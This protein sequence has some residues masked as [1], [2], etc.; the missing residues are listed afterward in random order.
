MSQYQ[1]RVAL[2]NGYEEAGS[3]VLDVSDAGTVHLLHCS[4]LPFDE[5]SLPYERSARLFRLVEVQLTGEDRESHHD[6]KHIGSQPAG[7]L[8][9]VRHRDETRTQGRLL[10]IDQLDAVTGLLVTSH[11][12][13]FSALPVV[14]SWTTVV[15]QGPAAQTLE[16]VS[17]F[18]LDGLA[19]EG[20]LPWDEKMQLG[21]PHNAWYGEVQWCFSSFPA[22]GFFRLDTGTS[23]STKR[24][25]YG[26]LGTW[27]TAQWLPMG[28]LENL[29]AGAGIAWQIEHNG[30]WHWEVSDDTG[31]I[32]LRL[33]G[34]TDQESQWSKTLAPGEQFTSVP[35]ALSVG[36]SQSNALTPF[37]STMRALTG[38]RR[39]IRRPHSD[40][41]LLPVIF[42]D[43]MNCLNA[44]P[45]TEKELPLI[46]AAARAGC[47]I[48]CVDAGWYADG[49]WW[50]SV[51]EWLPSSK[52]FPNGIEE[53]FSAIQA[54][55][56]IPGL[57]L[58]LEVM[59]VHC[60]LASRVPDNWFFCRKGKR[61]IDH[62]RYQLDYRH[63][64]VRAYADEILDRL[65][66][67]YG[68]GY[69]K[70]DYNINAGVGTELSAE[71]AGDGLL[72]HNRAYLDW[73]EK[74]IDRYPE[75]IIENC[76]SG[77]MRMDYALLSRHSVQ[78]VSD[79]T[80]YRKMSVIAV[81][82]PTAVTPEQGAIWAYPLATDDMHAVSYNMVNALLGRVH[83]SGQLAQLDTAHFRL[84]QEAI[85]V[86]KTFRAGLPEAVPYWPLGL[87]NF[88]SEWLCLGLRMDDS[89]YLA[90]WRQ[91]S[92][93]SERVIPLQALQ[94]RAL[95]VESLYPAQEEGAWH[96]NVQHQQ[97]HV[98]LPQRYS[99]R[100]FRVQTFSSQE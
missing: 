57:W 88:S 85:T 75:L 47:E 73:L 87:P 21:V 34:P 65:I 98:S 16:Y 91:D 100:L 26:S 94:D 60:P 13:F 82:A 52:R 24:L 29:E 96:L 28:Y 22:L 36:R 64:G 53:V 54:H 89:L 42:N 41:A 61:V 49:D 40:T 19:K 45:T 27:S 35:V 2:M 18:A 5:T 74:V 76:S 37:E 55:G 78:S 67:Q 30:S 72:Q 23:S 51:G 14:R 69:I 79:Q 9:Y 38:Y 31:D 97:L 80:D 46:Q 66:S 77:G 10:E 44:D 99:A 58:E 3:L 43:Y 62:G 68:L 12:Q 39:R 50:D 25:S 6:V 17:S 81:N 4:S 11:L 84:V 71:S 63:P 59:G 8:R 33:S 93:E 70:M 48:Y 1:W 32:Y 83:L 7:R 56:M 15:N 95:Q 92:I 90:L 20:T 86:Y